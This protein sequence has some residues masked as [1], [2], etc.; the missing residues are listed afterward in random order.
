MI[1]KQWQRDVITVAGG[2]GGGL[3]RQCMLHSAEAY[4]LT[5][6]DGRDDTVAQISMRA[7]CTL[8]RNIRF[9]V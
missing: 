8:S 9:P 3:T 2:V 5:V 7:G 1:N 6:A 4:K